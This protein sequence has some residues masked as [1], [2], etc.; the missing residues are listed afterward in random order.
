MIIQKGSF[1]LYNH[2]NS[3]STTFTVKL[4][5]DAHP[6][7][8]KSICT[9]CLIS[10]LRGWRI[11]SSTHNSTHLESKSNTGVVGRRSSP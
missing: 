4:D 5:I 6:R 1:I 11:W 2:E 9:D 7:L 10:R 3:E 8:S